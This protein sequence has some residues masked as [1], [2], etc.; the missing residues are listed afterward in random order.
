MAGAKKTQ[1]F[2]QVD[3][4]VMAVKKRNTKAIDAT[5]CNRKIRNMRK[6]IGQ[7]NEWGNASMDRLATQCAENGIAL[8][9]HHKV[10]SDGVPWDHS[11]HPNVE[12]K[13]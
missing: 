1:E 10:E 11:V 4:T 5:K 8:L 13:L 6:A 7:E 12:V 3:C 2:T 9:I